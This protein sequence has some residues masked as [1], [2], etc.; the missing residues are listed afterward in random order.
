MSV[1]GQFRDGKGCRYG[2]KMK[3]TKFQKG[4]HS[5]RLFL[6][7]AMALTVWILAGLIARRK[8]KTLSLPSKSKGPRRSNFTI[9]VEAK[10]T[11]GEV[12]RMGRAAL[13]K[14]CPPAEIRSFGW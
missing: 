6:L 7:A 5:D 10:G 4:A 11:I 1:E 14:L 12:L 8:D 13:A 9:G 3:C 2:R